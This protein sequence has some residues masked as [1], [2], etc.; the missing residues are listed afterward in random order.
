MIQFDERGYLMPYAVTELKLADF[1]A[2]FVAAM[3]DTAHRRALFQNYLSFTEG[4]RKTF[5]A[6]FYQWIVGSF[7]TQKPLPGDLDVVTFLPF[8]AMTKK[9]GFVDFI[10]S[11]AKENYQIDAHFAYFCKWN[12]RFY[13]QAKEDENEFRLL[14]GF[15][16]EDEN[17][18]RWPKGIIIINFLQ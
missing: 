12:H 6:P 5:G 16:R 2:F 18:K 8:D 14:F 11:S 1:E 13:E 7:V 3:K 10:K 17:Q 9:A 15:S 4:L